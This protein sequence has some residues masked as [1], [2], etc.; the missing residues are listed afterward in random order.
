MISHP[1]HLLKTRLARSLPRIGDLR[2]PRARSQ[3]AARLDVEGGV[4]R[5]AP[6]GPARR[7][8]VALPGR[9]THQLHPLAFPPQLKYNVPIPN[10]CVS[11]S[12]I[13]CL[14]DGETANEGVGQPRAT[15]NYR[16]LDPGFSFVKQA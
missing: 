6:I 8:Q 1:H 11:I 13:D 10:K 15:T 3:T 12:C 7:L 2:P 4:P 9:T 16:H 5:N 14:W